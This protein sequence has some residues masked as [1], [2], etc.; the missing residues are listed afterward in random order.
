MSAACRPPGNA[1]AA[2]A[3]EFIITSIITAGP[4]SYQWL[5]TSPLAKIWDQMS[6]AKEYG[7][8]RIWIVNVGHFKGYE[9]PMQYFLDL[10]WNTDKWTN[11]N[12]NEY[13][14]LWA[15][16]QFGPIYA[17]EIA[18]ILAKYTKYN[19]RRKPELLDATIYSVVNYQEAEKVVADYNTIARE[20]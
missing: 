6:L 4:R 7:A 8:D 3:R 16:Q 11:E 15:E 13:T 9:L 17:A 18:D 20:S 2:A 5:N 19:G 10:A 14:R 12:I 1:N